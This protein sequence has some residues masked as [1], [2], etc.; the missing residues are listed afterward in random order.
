VVYLPAPNLPITED[1]L[2]SSCVQS[3][4]SCNTRVAV[5][6][7]AVGNYSLL[8]RGQEFCLLR[9]VD[10]GEECYNGNSYCGKSFN[11]KDPDYSS[12]VET[13]AVI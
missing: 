7:Q 9:P 10:D 12:V 11:D 4:H 2:D 13:L 8:F 5:V 3:V 1:T 6:G